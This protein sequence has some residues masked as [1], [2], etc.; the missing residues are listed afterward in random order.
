MSGARPIKIAVMGLGG[1]GGGVLAEWIVKAGE[2]AGFIAQSTSVPGVAQ[3]TGATIYYVELFPKSEADA[4]GKPPVLALMPAPADVDI[5]V[6]SEMMEAGRALMRG[7]VSR[8]TTMIASTH[9][10]FAISE[11]IALGDGRQDPQKVKSAVEAAAG[12]CIWF[13]MERAA[14][15]AGAVISAVMFG[16]LA[17]SAATPLPRSDFEETIRQAGRAIERNLNGFARGFDAA[18]SSTGLPAPKA[19]AEPPIHVATPALAVAP[20]AKRLRSLPLGVIEIAREGVKRSVDFQDVRYGALYLDRIERILNLDHQ[21]GGATRRLQ[22]SRLVAKHLALWMAY[23]DIVRVADLKTRRSRFERL[24]GDVRAADGQIVRVWEYLHP[25]VEEFCDLLPTG[26]A[27]VVLGSNG[28][29]RAFGAVL[30]KGRRVATTNVRGFLMLRAVASM[31][32]LRRGGHRYRAEQDRIEGWLDLVADT[33]A[34]DYELACE[35][36][37]LQRLIKGYG[38]THERGLANYDRIIGALAVIK[39]QTSPAKALAR[40]RDAALKDEGGEALRSELAALGARN[41]A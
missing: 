15:Q 14:E 13:D 31:R 36:A 6:A 10:V 1:Q 21:S 8:K 32:F 34:R 9:R 16:A 33:A 12:R 37:G 17:G 20:L 40:L 35:I 29:R 38:E 5:L 39:E 2:R 28:A 3:R 26:I 4:R 7:F 25:R 22:L 19:I 24:R 11:K 27:T 18:V 30:G 41:A 23:D